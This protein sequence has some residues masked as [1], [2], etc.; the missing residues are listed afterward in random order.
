[1]NPKK[2]LALMRGGIMESLHY[3]LSTFTTLFGN[4]IY[5]VLVYFLWKAIYAS[6]GTDTVG[7]MTFNDTMIYLIL[8]SAL[9]YFMEMYLVWDMSFDIQSGRVVLDLLKPMSY[10]KYKFWNCTGALIINFVLNFLPTFII[11][12]IITR[13]SIPIGINLL[14]F[15]ISTVLALMVNFNIDM[16]VSTICLYTESTWGINMV[17]E[18]ITLLLSG[19]TIPLAFFPEEMRKVINWLPFRA[20]YDAPLNFLLKKGDTDSLAGILSLF[21][22]QA[23]WAIILSIIGNLF[24]NRAVRKITVNGG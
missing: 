17:K 12:M 5:L 21:A 18:T 16:L 4:I 8:A 20:I 7:G 3:R 6:S 15:C 14:Y 23:S 1:M 10:R 13:G 19:A 11:V 24:W 22:F 2:A 9:F